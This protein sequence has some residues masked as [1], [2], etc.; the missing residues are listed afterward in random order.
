MEAARKPFCHSQLM[1]TLHYLC[2]IIN[3]YIKEVKKVMKAVSFKAF[4]GIYTIII[5]PMHKLTGLILSE[6][7]C[8]VKAVIN[9]AANIYQQNYRLHKIES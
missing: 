1:Q 5:K 9:C 6:H 4:S 8:S 7:E 2:D 3:V